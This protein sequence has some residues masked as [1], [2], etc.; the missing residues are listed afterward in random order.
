[1]AKE[2]HQDKPQPQEAEVTG[3]SRE[4]QY[5]SWALRRW[6]W[7]AAPFALIIVIF[8]VL[9]IRQARLRSIETKAYLALIEA[10]KPEQFTEIHNK[11]PKTVAGERALQRAADQLYE[12]G[13]FSASREHYQLYL[14]K[15]PEGLL[16]PWIQNGIGFT[17]EAE[18]KYNDAIAAYEEVLEYEY[19][20]YLKDQIKLNIGRC[21]EMKNDLEIAKSFYNQL[22]S[23]P[24]GQPGQFA[25]IWA[26]EARLKLMLIENKAP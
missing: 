25:G 12:E 4:E 21:Y 19:G 3:P 10:E 14:Q 7:F 20:K 6:Y 15:Y 18:E 24:A 23:S 16:A 8:L 17:F 5:A 9:G 26:G 2:I 22:I 11:Y 1:L 13:N